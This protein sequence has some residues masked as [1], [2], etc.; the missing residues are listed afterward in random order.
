MSN[1]NK[2]ISKLSSLRQGVTKYGPAPH[3]PVLMLAVI[4]AFEQG[5]IT[6]NCIEL[7]AELVGLFRST[8]SSVVATNHV[9]LIAQPFFHMRREKFW[10]H[11]LNPG[12]E[13][14]GKVTKQCKSINVLKTTISHV[15]LDDELYILLS[16][17]VHREVLKMKLLERYFPDSGNSAHQ[18]TS[19]N[20]FSNLENRIVAEAPEVYKSEVK[21]LLKSLDKE[22]YEEEIFVRGGVFKRKVPQIYNNSC[23]ISGLRVEA[24]INASL[25]DACHIVPF[26][27]SYDDTISNG[28]ALCPNLHRAFDRGLIAIDPESFKVKVSKQFDELDYSPYSIKQFE[29][30]KILL[31]DNPKLRPSQDNL[32]WHL[33]HFASNF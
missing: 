14:W 31:P 29:H 6:R 12:Y 20:C 24:V 18:F 7:S 33:D 27:Q 25:I 22:S 21:T 15:T 1:L 10:H 16:N 9:C 32:Q 4:T 2:Y 3:K 26:S 8:W 19:V 13:N 11:H 28:I 30:K 5:L 23:C 17:P